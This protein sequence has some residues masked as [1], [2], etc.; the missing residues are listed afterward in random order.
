MM[1]LAILDD[2]LRVAEK[3]SD[4]S[5]LKGRCTI[6]VFD[7]NLAVPDEAAKRLASFDMISLMRERM[8][9]PKSL[10]DKLP[11]LKFIAVTGLR[12]R[13]LDLEAA[14]ARGIVVSHS[15]ERPDST[16]ATPELAWG[17]VLASTRH[18]AFEDRKMRQ[19][20]WQNTV[21]TRLHGKTLG[22]LGL[23]R[24][25]RRV[26]EFGRVFGMNVIAWS[27][28]LTEEAAAKV[29]VKRVEKDELFRNSDVISIHLVLGDR[30]RNL[31]GAREFGLMK[32]TAHLINTSR[33]PIVN[34]AALIE[35]LNSHRIAGAGIDVSDQEPLPDNHPLR[36]LDNAVLAPHLGYWTEETVQG[37]YDDTVEAVAAYLDGRP[38]RVLRP[39][40][41]AR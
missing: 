14:T 10:I 31:V 24:L 38:I 34:E 8:A 30:T 21:G 27:Q 4:W 39:A 15:N 9:V 35:A 26:A 17:L 33:G 18:I 7:R 41:P 37:F 36:R 40:P 23:G 28:N 3:I 20:G 13:T 1:K 32:S 12:N 11:D 2:Y 25:G 19:G 5:A 22:L 16:H 6:E 29:G